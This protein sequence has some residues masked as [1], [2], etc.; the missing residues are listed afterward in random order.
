MSNRI[1]ITDS[2]AFEN[3]I[4]VFESTLPEMKKIFQSEKTITKEIDSTPTWTG[5]AQKALYGK[6]KQLEENFNPIEESMEIYIKFLKKTI[7]DYKKLDTEL[8]QKAEEFSE[9]LNVNS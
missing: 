8:S 5:E 2:N 6:Y 9:Q 1:V 3:V 4:S 7:E